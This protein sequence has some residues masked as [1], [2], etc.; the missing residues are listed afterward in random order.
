MP[1]LGPFWVFVK[2]VH[3]I[4]T[5][6]IANDDECVNESVNMITSSTSVTYKSVNER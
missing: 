6:W 2:I 4:D 3:F 1:I 5:L